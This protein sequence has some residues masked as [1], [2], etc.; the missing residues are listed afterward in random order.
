MSVNSL[1]KDYV[2]RIAVRS[3]IFSLA[4]RFAAP[5]AVILMYHSV[6]DDPRQL[7]DW[8]G[9]G[10]THEASTFRRQMEIVAREFTPVTLKEILLFLNDGVTL[11]R[12]AVAVTFDDGFA[13]NCE[14]AAPI[15][16]SV[17]ICATFY[18]TVDL[19]GTSKAPWYSRLQYAFSRT[20]K[21]QWVDVFSGKVWDLQSPGERDAALLN[22]F[23]QGAPLVANEQERIIREIEAMLEVAPPANFQPIMMNWEQLRKLREAGH[24]V[25]SH[26]LTHPNLA[27]VHDDNDLERELSESKQRIEAEIGSPIEHFSYP[28]PALNPQWS[29][30]TIAMTAK[31]GYKSAVTTSIGRVLAG[32]NPLC[33]KR[34]GAPRLEHRFRW[35]L[36]CNLLGKR[37][38]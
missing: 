26:T 5:S 18:A 4:G 9:P 23:D 6:R 7:A 38:G 12:R 15:L 1:S 24:I 21:L 36:E 30:K 11:P 25:G 20:R 19:I 35:T 22:T 34:I 28:H 3:G 16:S 31:T 10:I 13:D 17:G 27:H 37:A 33:L 8:V 14:V 2:R 32:D 29:D